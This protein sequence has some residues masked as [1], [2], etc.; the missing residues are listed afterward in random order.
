MAMHRSITE[1]RPDAKKWSMYTEQLGH[2]FAA[3]GV[4]REAKK[5]AILL[6]VCGP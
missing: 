4:E 5:K 6:S 3:N 1:Y 2:Y